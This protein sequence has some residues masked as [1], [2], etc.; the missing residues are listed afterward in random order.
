MRDGRRGGLTAAWAGAP[1]RPAL[2]TLTGVARAAGGHG[3]GRAGD[4]EPHRKTRCARV[5]RAHR[6]SVGAGGGATTWSPRA[7]WPAARRRGLPPGEAGDRAAGRRTTGVYP[8]CGGSELAAPKTLLVGTFTGSRLTWTCCS[9]LP[10]AGG[11][12]AVLVL[13]FA[14]T[15]CRPLNPRRLLV[16]GRCA[17]ARL[18]SSR[19]AGAF[20]ELVRDADVTRSVG[21]GTPVAARVIGGTL[22]YVTGRLP[23]RGRGPVRCP[24]RCCPAAAAA[25]A[26]P[27]GVEQ[28]SWCHPR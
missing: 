19:C 5:H 27:R 4:R 12:P 26:L 2:D 3:C 18:R 9:Y 11:L 1:A 14:T 28:L 13:T 16:A 21:T 24:T 23:R 8:L 20:V 7:R 10:P 25:P 6:G 22:F 15:R 17:V